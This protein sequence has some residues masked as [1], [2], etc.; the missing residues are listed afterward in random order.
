MRVVV[1]AVE[2]TLVMRK[3]ALPPIAWAPPDPFCRHSASLSAIDG[4][5]ER[6][7]LL[8]LLLV[9]ITSGEASRTTSGPATRSTALESGPSSPCG[10]A[11]PRAAA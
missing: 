10:P 2:V 11:E 7:W 5:M 3:D 6:L 8:C 1:V 4:L 9:P